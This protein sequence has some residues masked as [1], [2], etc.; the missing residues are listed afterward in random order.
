MSIPENEKIN[1]QEKETENTA[2]EFST[3][4]SD[5]SAHDRTESPKK[6][7]KR[8]MAAIASVLAVAVFAGGTV[9]VIK[10][11]PEKEEDTA[12]SPYLQEETIADFESDD[13]TTLTLNNEKGT[14]NLYSEREDASDD[15][16]NSSDSTSTSDAEV[17]TWYVEGV[18][19]ELISTSSVATFVGSAITVDVVREITEKTAAD[20]GLESPS[21]S[22][23][24]VDTEGETFS[25]KIGAESPDGSGYYLQ[26]SLSDKIYVVGSGYVD[27]L[28]VEALDFA[29]ASM[30]A[31]T[32]PDGADDYTDDSGALVY[33]DKLTVDSKNFSDTL[34][35]ENN[36]D[37]ELSS[38]V[39]YIITSPS[40][41]IAENVDKLFAVYTDGLTVSGA[42]TFDVSSE[43]LK[44][45]GL[46]D[47]DFKMTLEVM[48]TTL[49]YKF[50]LQEDGYYAAVNDESKLINKVSADTLSGFIGL[51]LTD[52]YSSWISLNSIDDISHFKVS[53]EGTVYD[54]AI[55]ANEDED[56]E[57]GYVIT[58][59]GE[60]ID[61][62][63][64]QN[65]YQYFISL[66]CT[67]YTVDNVTASADIT[68]DFDFHDGSVSSIKFFKSG[69][70]RYQYS[71][72]GIHMGKTT[73]AS[74]N[75]FI[76]Y[77]KKVAAGETISNIS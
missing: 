66:A 9:A 58:V 13:Y 55:A 72:D 76:K 41:R 73:S 36:P 33:F 48:G 21:I 71:V 47:P 24:A 59:N 43:S 51:E 54:F 10:L 18:D 22:F 35:V 46:N 25:V 45:F 2:E 70:T 77:L 4:F 29:S 26:T 57:D 63:S 75:K 6:K 53:A 52:F 67:D 23:N 11:I 31:F 50:A 19:K 8:L 44:K 49:T 14:L 15:T 38:Y 64:F 60:S 34:V 5:P 39:G 16:D 74:M 1:G 20:C 27:E 12:S 17:V 69:E 32:V 7:K 61:C 42:Y 28:Q 30:G 65:L 62:S 3:V 37:E 40:K 56:A 68:V